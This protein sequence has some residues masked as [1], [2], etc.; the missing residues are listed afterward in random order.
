MNGGRRQRLFFIFSTFLL[1][2]PSAACYGWGM[3]AITLAEA[4][5][6]LAAT[7]SDINLMTQIVDGWRG[8]IFQPHDEDRSS[9]RMELFKAEALLQKALKLKAVIEEKIKLLVA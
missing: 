2:L 1:A 5:A 7:D 6:D 9:Y 3:E 8:F 4:R